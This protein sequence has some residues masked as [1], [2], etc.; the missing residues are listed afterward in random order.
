M[1][2]RLTFGL[3]LLMCTC[4]GRSTVQKA[5]DRHAL[6]TSQ[7]GFR[8]FEAYCMDGVKCGPSDEDVVTGQ[9]LIAYQ[10]EGFD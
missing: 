6:L 7:D 3:E 8:F 2:V 5:V 9:G 4:S 10:S 1:L